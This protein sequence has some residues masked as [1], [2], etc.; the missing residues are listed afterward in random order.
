MNLNSW[1]KCAIVNPKLEHKWIFLFWAG[2][3]RVA[4][5]TWDKLR[6]LKN[7]LHNKW[8]AC[9]PKITRGRVGSWDH[10]ANINKTDNHYKNRLILQTIGHRTFHSQKWKRTNPFYQSLQPMT[11][12]LS[13]KMTNSSSPSIRS[14]TKATYNIYWSSTVYHNQKS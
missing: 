9:S 11:S 13:W 2:R 1:N 4:S 3:G 14:M 8:K 6:R 5:P 7:Y 10:G 12:R